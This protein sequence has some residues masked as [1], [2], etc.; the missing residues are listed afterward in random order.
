MIYISTGGFRNL[1]P[2]SIIKKFSS[3]GIKSIE[4]SGGSYD[5]VK[6]IIKFLKKNKNLDYSLHNYF[7]VPKKHFVINLA[8]VNK[9]VFRQ[10]LLNIK[11]SIN[12]SNKFK[13]S[14]FGFHAGFLFDPNIKH[15]GKKFD[16]VKL[17][18]RKKTMELFLR[19][20]NLLAKEAKKRK[21]RF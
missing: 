8:S 10:S 9:K 1:K 5:E 14:Y 11:K 3:A 12:I 13:S 4:L 17:Q 21:S 20:V 18:N 2:Q 19:R 15:L 7:P 6:K 16:K